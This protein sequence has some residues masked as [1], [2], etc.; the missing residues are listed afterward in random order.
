MKNTIKDNINPGIVSN[1]LLLVIIVFILHTLQSV[2]I[3][4][5]FSIIISVLLYPL[6]RRLENL[7]MTRLSASLTSLVLAVLVVLGLGYLL[8]SQTINIGNNAADIFSKIQGV[9]SKLLDWASDQFNMSS[10]ELGS[11]IK[12]RLSDSMSDMGSYLTTALGS[13]GNSLSSAILVP[14]MIFFFLYYRDFFREF[15]FRAFSS[16]PKEIIEEGLGRIYEVLKSYLV[17]LVTVMGIVAVLN[18]I[19]LYILGIEYA[20]FFGILAALLTIFPYIGIFVGSM[21]PAL[22]ALATKDSLWY[23]TGVIIWFQVVQM[24][25]GNFITPNIV[26]GKASLNPLVSLLSFFLGGMLFGLAGMILALPLLAMLK[27]I[28]DIIPQTQAYGFLLSEPER[29]YLRS[30]RKKKKSAQ[31]EEE[32]NTSGK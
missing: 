7:R 9:A 27:V 18:T 4:I 23:A 31:E 14:I 10:Y 29:S 6:C 2:I 5:L 12:T 24:L 30:H 15:F 22:F 1:L 13:L 26:G 25:E 32:K 20:W 28:F 16:T 21:I 11:E 19:G 8:V 3:P 17:G